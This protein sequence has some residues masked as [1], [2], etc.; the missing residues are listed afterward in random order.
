MGGTRHD[1]VHRPAC[2]KQITV[3]A[4]DDA[5]VNNIAGPVQMHGPGDN[6]AHSDQPA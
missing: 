3:D 4:L 1:A 5:C 2:Q 6:L